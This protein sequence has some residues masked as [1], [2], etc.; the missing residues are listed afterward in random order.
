MNLKAIVRVDLT[1]P[2]VV[3]L[4]L[5]TGCGGGGG[6]GGDIG[7]G[8]S[9]NTTFSSFAISTGGGY[10][11]SGEPSPVS[12]A[13]DWSA[14]AEYANSTGLAQVRA[15]EGY[16]LRTGGLPGGEGVKVAVIDGGIDLRHADLQDALAGQKAFFYATEA[17]VTPSGHGTH[18]AGIIG[19]TRSDNTDP[20]NRHGIAYNASIVP[21]QVHRPSVFGGSL[22]FYVDDVAHAIASAAGLEKN[23]SGAKDPSGELLISEPSA[24]ADIINLSLG[25]PMPAP[26]ELDAMRDAAA[27]G[28]IM[29]IATGNRGAD[30]PDYPA[31][32]VID[33]QVQGYSLAVGNLNGSGVAEP[34][35]NGCGVT[36]A[37]C[38]FAPG[39]AIN[40]T[41][42]NDGY[43]EITGT[44]MA[45]P[46]VAGAAAV[47]QAAF[48]GVGPTDIVGRLLS[49]ADDLGDSDL[50]GHGR[51]NLE[52]A[53]TAV[54]AL[55]I[56]TGPT[57][58]DS[59]ASPQTAS[60][61]AG[62]GF[63]LAGLQ[64]E[65]MARTMVLDEQ[66][67]PFWVDLRDRADK[68]RV[69]G[70]L[71]PFTAPAEHTS[72]IADSPA[73]GFAARI[74]RPAAARVD[75]DLAWRADLA[76]TRQ[77]APSELRMRLALNDRLT[78]FAEMRSGSQPSVF[79]EGGDDL[80]LGLIQGGRWL[81]PLASLT[82]P[83]DRTG[84]S[85]V[86]TDD[87]ALSFAASR[88]SEEHDSRGVG[89]ALTKRV[90]ERGAF[91]LGLGDHRERGR[92]LG[93]EGEGA[94]RLTKG[95]T[96]NLQLTGRWEVAHG[97]HLFA[98]VTQA[99]GEAG[100]AAMIQDLDQV[101]ARA[102]ALGMARQDVFE[103]GDRLTLTFGQPLRVERAR[104]DL[105]VPVARRVD[106]TIDY[107]RD[108]VDLDA[109]GRELAMEAVYTS[110]LAE[111][112]DLRLGGFLRRQPDHDPDRSVDVGLA[113]R[114][115]FSF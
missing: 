39:T 45:A 65:T 104:A 93:S 95:L 21:I 26:V 112:M 63:G 24:E 4:V 23:Y 20:N 46:L 40:S 90:G 33:P 78:A 1:R 36:Q 60:F 98:S 111:N 42:P 30:D 89:I 87:L 64:G 55:S 29:V 70:A 38:L 8:L 25:G 14:R 27:R 52:A 88:S 35:S 34:T 73:L 12:S 102:F 108:Q 100:G 106:G 72:V 7:S 10:V 43:G 11:P 61:Q 66:G 44:S 50:Y 81:Q 79:A 59:A 57:I 80:E 41:V 16:A 107:R 62:S 99:F 56:P 84:L 105:A 37:Y 28:K 49:S 2:L 47:L 91:E 103:A 32:Y 114:L 69:V 22:Q 19:A 113:F 31:R 94:F 85:F 67:F 76:S 101:R 71:A 115:D 5:L 74:T 75:E 6:G 86:L 77:D 3:S 13:A 109:E 48:P 51:L 97:T 96:R 110:P 92:F 58:A 54:G 82:G 68:A 18:V 15:A 9:T 53:M 83:Q 17:G